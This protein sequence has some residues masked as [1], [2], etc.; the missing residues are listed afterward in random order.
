MEQN[1]EEKNVKRERKVE[2]CVFAVL[3]AVLIFA[4]AF[5]AGW[6]GRYSA[7]GKKKRELLW[8]IDTTLE[9]Y[10]QEI[11]EDVLYGKIYEGFEL[12]DYSCFYTAHE[13]KTISDEKDGI[14]DGAGFSIV[15]ER[16]KSGDKNGYI[17]IY[18]VA[19]NSPADLAGLK[20]G[21]YI[22]A[23]GADKEHLQTQGDDVN[24]FYEGFVSFA[25]AQK[26]AFVIKCGYSADGTDAED[27][28]ITMK[29]Y[30]ASYCTY[31]DSGASYAFRGETP[32]VTE[33]FDPLS[34]LDDK[35]AYISIREFNGSAATEF[36]TFLDRMKERGRTN[37]VLDLRM[38]GGGYID[39]LMEISSHLLKTATG[40][41]PVIAYAEFRSGEKISYTASNCD[42]KNYFKDDSEITVLA[43]EW[44][45]SASEC[46]IGAMVDY[47][48]IGYDDVV[49]RKDPETGKAGTYGKGVMQTYFEDKSGNVLK[50]TVAEIF[51]P[52]GKSIHGTGVTATDGAK[53]VEAPFLYDKDDTF[54]NSA[55]GLPVA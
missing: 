2:L 19:G 44:T 43:D 40:S 37:L 23:F 5:L 17:R 51:W 1:N 54:I 46:L 25:G 33:T 48:T 55:L 45:A 31:R 14:S 36:K 29:K 21:M 4:G 12:D 10:Y 52:E 39:I 13:Y 35:T 34:S 9:N 47:G 3:G 11:D 26:E 50:L 53:T 7:L 49:L 15:I 30:T 27:Y 28:S 16:G 41:N 8:A 42:Y 24:A 38:N 32:A 6:F 18:S 22:S 20:R